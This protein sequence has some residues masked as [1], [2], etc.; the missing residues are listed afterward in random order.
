MLFYT[1]KACNLQAILYQYVNRNLTRIHDCF[2]E[3][4][5]VACFTKGKRLENYIRR[6]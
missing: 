5:D 2:L 1:L 6:A 4:S 3:P